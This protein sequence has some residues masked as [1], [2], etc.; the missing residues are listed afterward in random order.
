MIEEGRECEAIA[1]QLMAARAALDRTSLLILTQHIEQCLADPRGAA[2]R[3]QL[4]R[5]I[6][7]FL[8]LSAPL[9]EMAEDEHSSGDG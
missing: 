3:A 5:V 4:E 1:T 7:F 8:K 9:S 2:S 6:S